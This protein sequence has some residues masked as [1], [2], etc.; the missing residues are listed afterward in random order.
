MKM[1][2]F[3]QI[4][5]TLFAFQFL[6][7]LN[8]FAQSAGTFTFKINPVSHSGSYGTK[9]VVAIWI[10]NSSGAFIKTKLEDASNKTIDHLATWTSKSN[11]NVVDAVTGSTLTSYNPITVTW[12]GTDV[13]K[14]IVPD[15]DYKIWIEM[16][17]DNS[18]TT[19]KTVTS[20]DFA[21]SATIFNSTPAS[22]A[23]FTDV[24]LNWVPTVT[25]AQPGNLV[26][27]IRVFPNPTKQLVNVDF[28]SATE[29][30]T[31]QLINP[32]GKML[33]QRK[34]SPGTTGLQVFDLERYANGL[35]FISVLNNGKSPNLQFKVL[36]NK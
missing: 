14:T 11:S 17:W 6:L 3:K 1:N 20:Y 24:S 16:A 31:I 8:A 28:R 23:F 15:G 32:A 35:Y 33:V 34:I 22:T 18:K 25:V 2:R 4:F 30:C 29:G 26:N 21:K 5:P 13:S 27:G 19:A 36:L 12:D 10:E 7:T 9:H